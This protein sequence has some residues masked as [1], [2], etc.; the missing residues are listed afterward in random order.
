MQVASITS[1]TDVYQASK[2]RITVTN[3][4]TGQQIALAVP[5]K[6]GTERVVY[7]TSGGSVANTLAAIKGALD[8]NAN[9]LAEYST[10]GGVTETD[11][12]Q[13]SAVGPFKPYIV[14]P[15][16]GGLAISVVENVSPYRTIRRYTLALH[17][18]IA[19]VAADIAL[20][21]WGSEN[22][23][24]PTMYKVV[25]GDTTAGTVVVD[26]VLGSKRPSTGIQAKY[27]PDLVVIKRAEIDAWLP[28]DES[29]DFAWAQKL[30]SDIKTGKSRTVKDAAFTVNWMDRH[31]DLQSTTSAG[32]FA[33]VFDSTVGFAGQRV[34][35]ILPA[36]LGGTDAFVT[37]GLVTAANAA[38][39]KTMDAAGDRIEAVYSIADNGTARWYILVDAVA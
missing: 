2:W 34:T 30:I 12:T 17:R 37:A 11:I 28:F 16:T 10:A 13:L 9:I 4:V 25:S 3:N 33:A 39:N 24:R 35:V 27:I 23:R 29:Y 1:V 14:G 32:N 36:A 31:I 26:D 20:L 18:P 5:L 21:R 7:T 15:L 38:A 22:S 19:V 6:D 8:A